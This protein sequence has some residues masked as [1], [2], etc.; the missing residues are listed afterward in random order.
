MTEFNH[1]AFIA[2]LRKKRGK[3]PQDLYD[4]LMAALADGLAVQGV[5]AVPGAS[6][7]PWLALA[8]THIGLK[9]VPGAQHN[10]TILSWVKA[11]GGWFKDDETP[12][13]G[14]FVGFCMFKAGFAPP[15]DWYRA[16]D[17]LNFGKATP[18]RV[19]AIAVFGREGGGHVGFV[20]GE[21]A[22][23]LYVLGGN[24]SNAVS[25]MPIGKDRLLGLRWP[26][27]LA[28]SDAT[29]PGMSGGASSANEA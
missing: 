3:I 2:T 4:D 19:G 1:G 25:I 13:C 15:K 24:Q 29:L 27:Q 10:A 8:R 18:P 9:E 6:D 22:S 11:L 7:P 21:D 5:P 17:W 23:R 28:L 20:V 12:W 16:K 26:A 14:T